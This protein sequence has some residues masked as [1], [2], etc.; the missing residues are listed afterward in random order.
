MVKGST[1]G[2]PADKLCSMHRWDCS[3]T[4][5][6]PISCS[7]VR[8]PYFC[9]SYQFPLSR[10]TVSFGRCCLAGDSNNSRIRAIDL[11]DRQCAV[12]TLIGNGLHRVVDGSAGQCSLE[13]PYYIIADP[14]GNLIISCDGRS[15]RHYSP[16]TG[17]VATCV[18]PPLCDKQT[19]HD[20]G[21]RL[22][23]R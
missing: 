11:S 7:A 22:Q 21:C 10:S 2:V 14:A 9:V 18:L 13:S 16:K 1:I 20:V 8:L 3:S 17:R 15:V 5:T 23:A 4:P 6:N 19:L 12:H